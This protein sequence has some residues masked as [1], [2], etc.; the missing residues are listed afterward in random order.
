MAT[1]LHELYFQQKLQLREV[2][3]HFR[4]RTG[5]ELAI[6]ESETTKGNKK[7][8]GQRRDTYKGEAI[9]ISM[10]VKHGHSPGNILRVHYY[11]HPGER[12]LIIGHCG[13]HLDTVKTN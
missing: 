13:D 11:P 2:V 5:F 3:V 9:D 10:H 1:V 7:L 6:G 4:N 8:A 12:R